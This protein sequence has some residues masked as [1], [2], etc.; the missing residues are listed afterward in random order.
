MRAESINHCLRFLVTRNDK[1]TLKLLFLFVSG[2]LFGQAVPESP[3]GIKANFSMRSIEAYQENSQNKL[4][5]FYEYLSFYS[6]ETNAE[7]RNQIKENIFSMVE[8]D[9]EILDFTEINPKKIDLEEFLSKIKNKS[10]RFSIQSKP[11]SSELGLNQWQN[12]YTLSVSQKEKTTDFKL[13]Q[14]I[15]FEPK[16]KKFGSKTKTVWEVKLGDIQ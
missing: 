6:S 9:V 13:N 12:V 1:V 3:K 7:L 2:V 5:E 11:A 15:Y 4:E 14:I 10:Y 8:T 16:E